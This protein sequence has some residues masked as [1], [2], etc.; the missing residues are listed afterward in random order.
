M[1]KE[2]K[3]QLIE[4]INKAKESGELTAHQ[5]YEITR[6]G[7]AETAQKLK[8]GAKDL[9]EIT[10]EAV[11]TTVQALVDAGDASQEK[12]SAALHGAVDGVKQTES[13]ILETTRKELSLAKKQLW[14]EEAKLAEGLRTAMGGAKE[15][16]AASPGIRLKRRSTRR[17]TAERK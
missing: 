12:I 3:Q 7:V 10:K 14:K 15:A 9:R 11:M 6:N 17:S 16:A 4:N 8:G 13:Q 5:V 1:L 2:M